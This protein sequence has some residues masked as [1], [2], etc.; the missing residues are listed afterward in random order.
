MDD[1]LYSPL[2]C[3]GKSHPRCAGQRREFL[4]QMGAGFAGLALTDLLHCDGF[5]SQ[6]AAA[7]LRPDEAP[8]TPRQPHFTAPAK[9]VIFLFMYGG[10]SQVDSW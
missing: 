4:W 10:P 6:Q 2:A 7:A 5:F 9:H 1:S 3:T 8:M